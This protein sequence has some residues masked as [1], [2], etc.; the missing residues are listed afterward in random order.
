MNRMLADIARAKEPQQ[1]NIDTSA[2]EG[3]VSALHNQVVSIPKNTITRLDADGNPISTV[4]LRT[5]AELE[6]L[7]GCLKT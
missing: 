3:K 4:I 7:R 2:S 5:K 6:G 1:I